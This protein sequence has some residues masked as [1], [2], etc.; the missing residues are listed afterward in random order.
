MLSRSQDEPVLNK[1][2]INIE[3]NHFNNIKSYLSNLEFMETHPT[4]YQILQENANLDKKFIKAKKS[5][6]KNYK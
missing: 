6:M 5:E 3:T 2:I 1:R 4:I